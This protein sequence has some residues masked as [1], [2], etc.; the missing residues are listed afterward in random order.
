M[1]KQDKYHEIG[2]II[3]G[4]MTVTVLFAT[5]FF[6]AGWASF[7]LLFL[8]TGLAEFLSRH[9][10][11]NGFLHLLFPFAAFEKTKQRSAGMESDQDGE[12]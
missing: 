4:L 10:F 12:R 9:L 11:N 7:L 8:L 2:Q 1:T 5:S 3:A 6:L